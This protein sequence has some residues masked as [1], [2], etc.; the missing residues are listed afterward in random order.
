MDVLDAAR[1][2]I[3]LRLL[4]ECGFPEDE[5]KARME[6]NRDWNWQV[7]CSDKWAEYRRFTA[8]Q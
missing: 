8:A 4:I 1:N 3:F 6:N 5:L 7:A 2:V